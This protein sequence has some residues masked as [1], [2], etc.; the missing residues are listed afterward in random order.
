M[1]WKSES[2]SSRQIA[3]LLFTSPAV[4]HY[5]IMNKIKLMN[6]KEFLDRRIYDNA[7]LID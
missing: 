7:A 3:P 6:F 1:L 5:S 4:I 2:S